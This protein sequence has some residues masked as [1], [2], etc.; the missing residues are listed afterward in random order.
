MKENECRGAD[1]STILFLLLSLICVASSGN[2]NAP[3]PINHTQD[4]D[5]PEIN[6]GKIN[7]LISILS[8][9]MQTS[10]GNNGYST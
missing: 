7:P 3:V 9:I 10:D 8:L 1:K 2:V 5:F 6:P 4:I